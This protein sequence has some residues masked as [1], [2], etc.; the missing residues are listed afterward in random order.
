MWFVFFVGKSW[1][2]VPQRDMNDSSQTSSSESDGISSDV[3]EGDGTRN[4]R[5][6]VYKLNES[7]D[8]SLLGSDISIRGVCLSWK[9]VQLNDGVK[10]SFLGCVNNV[11]HL[12]R[13]HTCIM[14]FFLLTAQ[15]KPWS[16][17]PLNVYISNLSPGSIFQAMHVHAF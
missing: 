16:F 10:I 17:P 5:R 13:A 8:Q 11:P 2:A 7:L 4:C 9:F 15:V 12:L 14:I 3:G 1:I 6:E